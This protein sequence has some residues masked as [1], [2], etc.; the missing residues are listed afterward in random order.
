M[1]KLISLA[2]CLAMVLTIFTIN[3][4]ALVETGETVVSGGSAEVVYFNQ[5]FDGTDITSFGADTAKAGIK[6]VVGAA[7]IVS[8]A[9]VISTGAYTFEFDICK[10]ANH[11]ATSNLTV[12]FTRGGSDTATAIRLFLGPHYLTAGTWYTYRFTLDEANYTGT[13][14]NANQVT[15]VE[16]KEKNAA[17]FTTCNLRATSS[18]NSANTYRVRNISAVADADIV[19]RTADNMDLSFDNIKAYVP[20]VAG[21]EQYTEYSINNDMIMGTYT[22][23]YTHT[24]TEA[25]AADTT[26]FRILVDKKNTTEDVV[27]YADLKNSG[28]G[29]YPISVAI[30]SNQ[31]GAS[32]HILAT[33]A[34]KD[35]WY[36]YKICYKNDVN[37][38]DAE[39]RVWRIVPQ[40]VYR[41]PAAGGEWT[42]LAEGTDW[43]Q[44]GAGDGFSSLQW[45]ND[46]RLT[47]RVQIGYES[48][49]TGYT[50]AGTTWNSKN[51]QV[52]DG[53]AVTGTKTIADGKITLNLNTGIYGAASAI[54]AVYDGDTLADAKY[55][56]LVATAENV[57]VTAA[58]AE[59]NDV[60][61]YV[62]D[63]LANAKPIMLT[64]YPV[65]E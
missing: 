39:N 46:N 3:A 29:T 11:T 42:L 16:Y 23:E 41:R 31:Y 32:A 10:N 36:T 45:N 35:V 8:A 62:W 59:G 48:T 55:V 61:L 65:V 40:T 30:G 44:G 52:I 6:T 27:V 57:T 24:L 34:I 60:V 17:E 15:K 33:N 5:Q 63:S 2:L 9:D 4:S 1:K 26:T 47:G 18:P 58:Y 28:E 50:A 54:L 64:P 53:C 19:I 51:V 25:P 49:L 7:D 38:G 56:D 20:E 22:S 21:T 13:D 43:I 14:N 37:I 12:Y